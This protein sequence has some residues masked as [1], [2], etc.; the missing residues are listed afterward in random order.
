MSSQYYVTEINLSRIEQLRA[1]LVKSSRTG[2]LN[3]V[4]SDHGS[5]SEVK[6][7]KHS[8]TIAVHFC[9]HALIIVRLSG[10]LNI[11]DASFKIYAK[12]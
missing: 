10:S 5:I 12:F 11:D 3:S 2:G 8:L 9:V 1:R 6:V 4:V 7:D